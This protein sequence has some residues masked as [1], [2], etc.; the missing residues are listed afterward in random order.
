MESTGTF[1]KNLPEAIRGPQFSVDELLNAMEKRSMP[2]MILVLAAPNILPFINAL[3]I[4]HVTGTLMFFLSGAMALG[5]R[6]PWLPRRIRHK[7]LEKDQLVTVTQ[8]VAPYLHWL[9]RYIRPRFV[10]MCRPA[11]YPF[12][13]MVV[14]ILTVILLLPLPFINVLPALCIVLTLL[15]LLQH[16]GIMMLAVLALNTVFV[17]ALCAGFYWLG[18][19]M[20]TAEWLGW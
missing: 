15:A 16:D 2:L 11:L 13:G 10:M 6:R 5:Q 12:Y 8:R 7:R 20:Y 1:V 9:E 18:E 4:T 3:G 14:F 17:L 19:A